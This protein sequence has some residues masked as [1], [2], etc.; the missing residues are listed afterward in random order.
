MLPANLLRWEN[1]LFANSS[2]GKQ[3]EKEQILRGG[4]T[5][6]E[7]CAEQASKM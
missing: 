1:G 6:V 2:C 7:S 3:T 5:C 4:G